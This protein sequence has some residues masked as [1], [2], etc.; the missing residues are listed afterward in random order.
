MSAENSQR[1]LENLECSLKSPERSLQ[2]LKRRKVTLRVA[3]VFS[4]LGPTP[5]GTAGAGATK[6]PSVLEFRV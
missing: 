6:N 3:T 2:L 1:S 4:A 5:E